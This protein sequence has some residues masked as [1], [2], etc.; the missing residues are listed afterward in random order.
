MGRIAPGDGLRRPL[1]DGQRERRQPQGDWQQRLHLGL[2]LGHRLLDA[3]LRDLRPLGNDGRSGERPQG[4]LLGQDLH[5]GRSEHEDR[6]VRQRLLRQVSTVDPR[7]LHAARGRPVRDGAQRPVGDAGPRRATSV[8]DRDL[9]HRQAGQAGRAQ[10]GADH[11]GRRHADRHAQN[12]GGARRAERAQS[13]LLDGRSDSRREHRWQHG[14]QREHLQA[15][16]EPRSG[17]LRAYITAG[18]GNALTGFLNPTSYIN[19]SAGGSAT[20]GAGYKDYGT[21]VTG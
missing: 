21:T 2:R 9:R 12:D 18:V 6:G 14:R 13:T 11:F 4:S 8:F 15:A 19:P 10:P 5:G 17:A 7:L 20:T 1:S 3:Q 16:T